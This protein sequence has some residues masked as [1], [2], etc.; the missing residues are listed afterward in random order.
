[1]IRICE[2]IHHSQSSDQGFCIISGPVKGDRPCNRAFGACHTEKAF[3]EHNGFG[4]SRFPFGSREYANPDSVN[5][6]K[7]E[8]PNATWHETR[9]FITFIFPTYKE[10]HMHGIAKGI[11]KVTEAYSG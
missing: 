8:T 10:E 6:S 7:V 4:D 3:Q 5:Y 11:R 1:M 9:T 2:I